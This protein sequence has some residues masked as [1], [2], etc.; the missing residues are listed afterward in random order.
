M[1]IVGRRGWRDWFRREGLALIVVLLIAAGLRLWRLGDNGFGTAY[2]AA[3]VRSMLQGL[4]LFF[5]N[6]FDP[7]GFISLDKPPVAFWIQTVFAGLLGYS[8]W[9]IHLP[10]ALAGVVS[11]WLVHRLVRPAFGVPAGL[12]AA[13]LLAL[14][15]IAVAVDRSNNTD[16]WLALF[17]LLAAALALRGRGLALAASMVLLG[18]AFNVKMMA[19]LVCGPALLAAWLLSTDLAWRRRVGWMAASG[20]VLIVVSLSWAAAFDLTP[21]DHRPYAGSS[22]DNSMLELIVMHNALERFVRPER[23]TN[24][25]TPPPPAPRFA[26]YDNVPVGPLRL[27]QPTLAPQFAW[28]VPVAVIGIVLGW[29]RRRSV[30]A[31]WALWAIA[32]GVVY[33][34]AGGIFHA[35]YLS[36]LAP[37]LAALAGIGGFELWRRGPRHLA[38]GLAVTALWQGY[39]GGSA[40]GW[41][42]WWLAA[43]VVALLVGGATLWRGKRP[44]ALIGLLLLLVLPTAWTLSVLFAPGNL[45]LPSASLVRWLG[46]DDG[47]GP[48]LSRDWRALTDDPKLAAFLQDN[49]GKARF[50]LAAPNALLAAPVIVR[51]GQPVMAFGGFFGTDPVMDVDAFAKLVERGEVRY[52]V[53]G[54][55]RRQSEFERWVVAHGRPVDP[56]AWRS[57]PPEPRRAVILFD[58]AAR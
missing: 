8:G 7:A 20:G 15:P 21:R 42:S 40:V 53:L 9:T 39:I 48:I 3:G 5:Y 12:A 57:L 30:I 54:S 37:P 6:A 11:V 46:R 49:R 32:Y 43:P 10:Q 55:T 16:S 35:Y 33:S 26:A 45:T 51:T 23:P 47:R 22:R 24:P 31:L 13:L 29:R 52:A 28:M 25:G 38:I 34:A 58:L 44:P 41:E 27:A 2:Y 19:A 36:T 14:S 17:L 50:L 1:A 56:A 4:G 18:I